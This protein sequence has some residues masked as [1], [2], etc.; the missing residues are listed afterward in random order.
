[1][2]QER[3]VVQAQVTG[4]APIAEKIACLIIRASGM[5]LISTTLGDDLPRVFPHEGVE[6]GLDVSSN[7]FEVGSV[8]IGKQRF[9][10]SRRVTPA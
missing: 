1:M 8:D 5:P 7:P 4:I 9:S 6:P 10:H 2:T 3:E